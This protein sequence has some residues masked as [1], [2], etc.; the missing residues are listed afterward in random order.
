VRNVVERA[1]IFFFEAFA[2]IFRGYEAGFAVGQVASGFFAE[3]YEG[4]VGQSNDVSLAIDKEFRVDGVRV[5]GGDAVPHVREA[6]LV[7]LPRQFGNHFEGADE[8]THGAGIRQ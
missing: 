5:A 2:Q 7:G 4:G 6:A 8:L 3:F 1:D